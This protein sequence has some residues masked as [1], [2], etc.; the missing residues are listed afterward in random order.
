MNGTE[1][2]I[3][4]QNGSDASRNH[5]IL[6]SNYKHQLVK[7]KR[8]LHA[9]RIPVIYKFSKFG[10]QTNSEEMTVITYFIRDLQ[11][12]DLSID[13]YGSKIYSR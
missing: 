10:R 7:I 6:L 3:E 1:K 9:R 11:K 13:L 2:M 4:S 5:E 12:S 8:M